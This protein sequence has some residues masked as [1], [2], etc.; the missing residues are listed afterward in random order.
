MVRNI[1]IRNGILGKIVNMLIPFLVS[2]CGVEFSKDQ[3]SRMAQ[4]L[5]QELE[6]WRSRPLSKKYP[7]LVMDARYEYIR[8]DGHIESEGVL[9]VKD[10]DEGG[11]REILSVKVAP[12][13]DE[14][15]WGELL[16]DLL[17]R[18][19]RPKSV[20]YVVSDEHLGLKGGHTTLPS[21]SCLAAMPDPLSAQCGA[22]SAKKGTRAGSS[23]P[24]ARYL[25]CAR[26]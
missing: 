10:V 18:G 8:E 6:G 12:G 24:F 14:T 4:T 25:Q 23:C 16:A 20:R 2:A 17:K 13:E 11:Y 19:L 1:Q 21:Q 7:Y 22:E 26:S 5:D 3:V 9:T 15:S